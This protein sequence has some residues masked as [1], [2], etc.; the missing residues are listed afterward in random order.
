[1]EC[2]GRVM[3]PVEVPTTASEEEDTPWADR[4]LSDRRRPRVGT[5]LEVRR[6][7]MGLGPSIG[8]ET[9]DVSANGIKVRIRG[10][11]R[12]GDRVVITLR[13]P[14][15]IWET[16]ALAEVCWCV[17]AKDGTALAGVKFQRPLSTRELAELAE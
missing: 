4:R 12:R 14:G 15:G 3:V 10:N 16:R 1:M 7:G 2:C 11:L 6:G 5:Q 9:E 17:A 8:I 13:P